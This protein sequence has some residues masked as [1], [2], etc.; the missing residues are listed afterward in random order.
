MVNPF[1]KLNLLMQKIVCSNSTIKQQFCVY[2]N[3]NKVDLLKLS[4]LDS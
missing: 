1:A 2:K 3:D 4:R